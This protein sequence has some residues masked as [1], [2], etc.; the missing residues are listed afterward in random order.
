MNRLS[1]QVDDE[2][3]RKILRYIDIGKKEGAKLTTGGNRY[4]R[5]RTTFDME[6]LGTSSHRTS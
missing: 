1:L 4:S 6:T 2:Q 5:V 3:M